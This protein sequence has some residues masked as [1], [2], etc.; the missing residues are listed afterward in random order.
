MMVF[1]ATLAACVSFWIARSLLR[2]C[3]EETLFSRFPLLAD[4]NDMISADG[5]KVGDGGGVSSAG[6][7]VVL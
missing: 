4:V 6:V 7:V 5:V 1:A 3:I 2:S